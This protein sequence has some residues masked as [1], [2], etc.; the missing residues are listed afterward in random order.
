[1][2]RVA[3]LTLAGMALALP[4]AAQAPVCASHEIVAARLMA[5]WAETRQVVGLASDGAVL[6]VFAN[7]ETGTWTL[8]RSTPDGRA[9]IVAAGGS[10]SADPTAPQGE[11]A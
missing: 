2:I 1:M 7:P 9:C 5:G 3:I 10:Y 4:A 6:E 8:L 11:P